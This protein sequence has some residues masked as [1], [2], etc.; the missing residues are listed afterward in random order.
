MRL[1]S[2]FTD[3]CMPAD[4]LPLHLL[5]PPQGPGKSNVRRFIECCLALGQRRDET[6]SPILDCI[7]EGTKPIDQVHP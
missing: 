7:M 2:G 6:P 3:G 4:I 5:L 1:Y